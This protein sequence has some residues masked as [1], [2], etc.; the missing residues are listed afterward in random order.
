MH[1]EEQVET[2]AVDTVLGKVEESVI[3]V[4]GLELIFAGQSLVL[5]SV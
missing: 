4:T 2:A 3:K 1:E 5:L